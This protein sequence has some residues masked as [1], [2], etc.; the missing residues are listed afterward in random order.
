MNDG[1]HVT[2]V[3]RTGGKYELA[4]TAVILLSV[5]G[6]SA[7]MLVSDSAGLILGVAGSFIGFLLFLYGRFF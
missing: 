2:L 7:G 5:G 4:G 3:K 6:C 1:E